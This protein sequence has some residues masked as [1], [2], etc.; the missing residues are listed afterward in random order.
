MLPPR[1]PIG[2]GGVAEQA[3]LLRQT[4]RQ[5]EAL[6]RRGDERGGLDEVGV[7][8]ALL[9]EPAPGGQP[10]RAVSRR[11]R[12][13]SRPRRLKT[14]VWGPRWESCAGQSRAEPRTLG[15]DPGPIHRQSAGKVGWF[16]LGW[17]TAAP[18]ATAKP[19]KWPTIAATPTAS[20]LTMRSMP[21]GSV[22]NAR[23]RDPRIDVGLAGAG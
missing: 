10:R 15:I 21:M 11:P 22:G 12:R 13:A 18:A 9:M 2:E 8:Q 23:P 7:R 14:P 19:S 1:S 3:E 16:P 17:S 5:E 6:D 20:I 4:E